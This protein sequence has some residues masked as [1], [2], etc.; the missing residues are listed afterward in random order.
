MDDVN[1]NEGT[2][3]VT[4]PFMKLLYLQLEQEIKTGNIL[5]I[6]NNVHIYSDLSYSW[7]KCSELYVF[8]ASN[9]IW[10]MPKLVKLYIKI[11]IHI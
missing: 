6:Y 9:F 1:S 2:N 10:A 3:F 4:L 5:Y 11:Y 8:C 7:R